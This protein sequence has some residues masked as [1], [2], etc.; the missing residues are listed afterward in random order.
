[1]NALSMDTSLLCL[2]VRVS[3]SLSLFLS[4]SLSLFLS[5]SLS[6]FLSLCVTKKDRENRQRE[7]FVSFFSESNR[8]MVNIGYRHIRER[9]RERKRKR[10]RTSKGIE[11]LL[12]LILVAVL[13]YYTEIQYYV[14]IKKNTC[15]HTSEYIYLKKL[16]VRVSLTC[17][18][19]G[20]S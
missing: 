10:E 16:N 6:L 7:K 2:C 11:P 17:R 19:C 18:S 4:F 3:L 12:F 13:L 8:H 1:M 9:D 14:Y 5:F 20:G 15:I